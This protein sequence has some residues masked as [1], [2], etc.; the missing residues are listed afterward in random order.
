MDH[1]KTAKSMQMSVF[2]S[3]VLKDA[4]SN[5]STFFTFHRHR[6]DRSKNE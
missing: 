4:P 5:K 3:L 1:Q 6:P 2:G